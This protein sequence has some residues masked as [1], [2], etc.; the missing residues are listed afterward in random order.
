MSQNL[1]SM[2]TESDEPSLCLMCSRSQLQKQVEELKSVIELLRTQVRIVPDLRANIEAM[3]KEI[4][5]LREQEENNARV[6]GSNA[7]YA[8]VASRR[9][10]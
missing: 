5:E 2:L 4:A 1:L 10:A 9:L 8:K 6:N 3:N 7:T